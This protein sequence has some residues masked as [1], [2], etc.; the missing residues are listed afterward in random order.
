MHNTDRHMIVIA[1]GIRSI[2]IRSYVQQPCYQMS[3]QKI[4]INTLTAYEEDMSCQAQSESGT[5]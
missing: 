5:P 3:D 2:S 1:K 4:V